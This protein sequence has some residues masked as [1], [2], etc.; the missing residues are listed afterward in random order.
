MRARK[1]RSPHYGKTDKTL[2]SRT[3]QERKAKG[4]HVQTF[5]WWRPFPTGQS[6]FE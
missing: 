4:H 6:L 2:D 5:R 3:N 1:K